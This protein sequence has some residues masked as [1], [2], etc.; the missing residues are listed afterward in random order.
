M[1]F[2][3]ISGKSVQSLYMKEF[4]GTKQ[5]MEISTPLTDQEKVKKDSLSSGF[6]EDSNTQGLKPLRNSSFYF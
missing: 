2:L 1:D 3:F 5:L 4:D 6:L